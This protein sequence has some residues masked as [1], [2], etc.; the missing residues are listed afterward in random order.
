MVSVSQLLE[1]RRARLSRWVGAAVVVCA[2][3]VGGAALALMHWPEEEEAQDAAGAMV[4]ELAPLLAATPVDSPDVAHGP[5]MQE[6]V[7][8]PEASQKTVE[9]VAKDIPV[10]EPSPAPEPE[11]ALPM[12]RPEVKEEPK[13]EEAKEAIPEQQNPEQ[14][15]AA[16]LTTAPPRVEAEPVPS[17][18]PS[19]GTAPS[20]ARVQ[21]SWQKKLIDH[22]NRHKRYPDE[23][24]SRRAQGAVIVAFSL[25]RSGQVVDSHVTKSSGSSALDD[26][27]VAV[28]RRA[29]PLP[30]PP[31]QI[32]GSTL[33]LV[34][35]IQFRIK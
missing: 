34:L 14:A 26:E 19:P 1:S 3:H 28:L 30:A 2:L 24:R 20:S 29:S 15:S 13:Q 21:A 23:A 33:D 25:D 11:V 22:L 12:P 7:L 9:E 4:V 10:V 8:T 6:A 16:P 32:A 31:D 27:A 18:A 5:L 17:A 35:P